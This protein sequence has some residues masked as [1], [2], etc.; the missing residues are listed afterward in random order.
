MDSMYADAPAPIPPAGSPPG[1]DT[2]PDR[3]GGSGVEID[4]SDL[5]YGVKSQ[6]MESIY[7]I[8]DNCY[9]AIKEK[10][11]YHLSEDEKKSFKPLIKLKL[12]HNEKFSHIEISDNG[13]GIKEE[14]RQKIFAP[15]F[16]TKPSTKSGA[17]VGMYVVKRIIEEN[18]KG[19]ISFE[20]KYM[21]GIKF[22]IKLPKDI[23]EVLQSPVLVEN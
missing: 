18:H 13:T 23:S 4:S 20:S 12:T 11:D 2:I 10:M 16:T 9:E 21:E 5:I 17:G 7:N 22:F 6:V 15:F 1:K 14:N 3:P 8:L 19:K